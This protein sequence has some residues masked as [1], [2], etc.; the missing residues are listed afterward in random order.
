LLQAASTWASLVWPCSI[1][2][3]VVGKHEIIVLTI[4]L[5]SGRCSFPTWYNNNITTSQQHNSTTAQQHNSTTAQQHNST[6][7]QQHNSTIAQHHNITTDSRDNRQHTTGQQD[8]KQAVSQ[9]QQSGQ[10]QV[11]H[12]R[13][14][15]NHSIATD[16][17]AVLELYALA[18]AARTWLQAIE[19]GRGWLGAPIVGDT[20]SRWLTTDINR[21]QKKFREHSAALKATR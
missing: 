10:V 13:S 3:T 5:V 15:H 20:A 6:T 16:K 12:Q 8:N 18:A 4:V 9:G 21:R 17:Q 7:A 11:V 19:S 14:P 2:V 1:R